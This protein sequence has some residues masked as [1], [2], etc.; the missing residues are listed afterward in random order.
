MCRVAEMMNCYSS[1]FVDCNQM[2]FNMDAEMRTKIN[3]N[4]RQSDE[5]LLTGKNAL[6]IIYWNV[7]D[8]RVYIFVLHIKINTVTERVKMCS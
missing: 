2:I 1:M 8:R 7:T 5:Q 6:Y 4:C 3:E